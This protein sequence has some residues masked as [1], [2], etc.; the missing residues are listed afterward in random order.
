MHAVLVYILALMGTAS[1]SILPGTRERPGGKIAFVTACTHLS[2]LR[3]VFIV[4]YTK[5]GVRSLSDKH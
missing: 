4:S 1:E 2:N 3:D 5:A